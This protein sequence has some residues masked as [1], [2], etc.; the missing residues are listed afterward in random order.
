MRLPTPLPLSVNDVWTSGL[1]ELTLPP[2][3][4]VEATLEIVERADFGDL[5]SR[6]LFEN[7]GSV[8]SC[9]GSAATSDSGIMRGRSACNSLIIT[10]CM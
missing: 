10:E 6:L 8:V 1:P 2:A 5:E 7:R 9:S 3:R 4:T